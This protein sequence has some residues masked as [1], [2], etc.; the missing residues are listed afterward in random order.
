MA[1]ERQGW[2]RAAEDQADPGAS[3]TVP[4]AVAPSPARAVAATASAST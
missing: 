3:R 4:E 2:D 1:S